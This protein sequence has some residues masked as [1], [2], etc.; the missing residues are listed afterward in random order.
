MRFSNTSAGTHVR[1]SRHIP[2]YSSLPRNP[3]P[4]C[5]T[6]S[7]YAASL[8]NIEN[9]RIGIEFFRAL[10]SFV[11]ARASAATLSGIPPDRPL[12]AGRP[13]FYPNVSR[14]LTLYHHRRTREWTL[15]LSLSFRVSL[16]LLLLPPLFAI[17]NLFESANGAGKHTRRLRANFCN[18]RGLLIL[19]DFPARRVASNFSFAR[20]NMRTFADCLGVLSR[21]I[22][23]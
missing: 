23:Y 2:L 13:V 10:S 16:S 8:W 15:L 9:A 12:S 22:N 4:P 3:C 1:L 19:A 5:L 6:R 7:T 17:R 18:F 21:F 11:G 20:R 14:W